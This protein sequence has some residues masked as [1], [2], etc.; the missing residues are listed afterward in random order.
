MA[1]LTPADSEK[2]QQLLD[3]LDI[4]HVHRPFRNPHWKP[5]QRRNKNVKQLISESSRKEASVMATQ[6]NSGASTPLPATTS[7]ST[8]G[9]QTPAEGGSRTNIAQAAQNLSTL[10]LEKNARAAFSGPTVTYT[11]IE[12]APSLNPSQQTRYCDITGLPAPYTDPKTRLRYH[13]KEVFGVVRTLGQGVPES[14]LEL[15]AAHV[16]LK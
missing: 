8:E 12:S 4:A 2:H 16:V 10:V 15:R 1:P 3:R 5:S 6:T 11:N 13:D 7:A 9:S 14:Y